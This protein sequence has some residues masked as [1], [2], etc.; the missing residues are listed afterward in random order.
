MEVSVVSTITPK[1]QTAYYKALEMGHT[2]R[3]EISYTAQKEVT[4]RDAIP[5]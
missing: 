2:A 3:S 1:L 5:M 4:R